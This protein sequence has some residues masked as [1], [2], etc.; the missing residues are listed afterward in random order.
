M[1]FA[2]KVFLV[3]SISSL[4][5]FAGMVNQRAKADSYGTQAKEES[6]K[7]YPIEAFFSTISFRGGFFS[8]DETK[9]LVSSD[10]TGIFNA[11]WIDI[12]TGKR[13][14]VTSSTAES[15]YASACF[16]ND[17]RI[18]YSSDKGGNRLFHLFVLQTDGKTVELTKGGASREEFYGWAQDGK[19]FFTVNTS[20]S[21]RCLDLCVRD[22]ETLKPKLVFENNG[23]Y[24][25]STI[26]PDGCWLALHK[27]KTT[28]DTDIYILDL[29]KGGEP[30]LI[31]AHEGEANFA[32][33]V[34]SRDSRYLYYTTDAGKDFACLKRCELET[35][36]HE[37]VFS[38]S[39]NV[40]FV[41][42]SPK[43]SYRVIGVE[44]DARVGI[45]VTKTA[46]GE[47]IDLPN[48]PTGHVE[49][50]TFSPSE[51]LM[52]ITLSND[53]LPN[54]I[55]LYNF[56]T[57]MLKQLTSALN[58]EIDPDDLVTSE[59]VR[60]KARDG[61]EIQGFLYKPKGAGASNKVP[62]LL[63]AHDGPVG[64]SRPIYSAEL[65]FLINHGY[66]IFAINQ[67][68]S[69]GYGRKFREADDRRWGREPLSDYLDAKSYLEKLDWVDPDRIGIMGLSIGGYFVLAGLTLHPDEFA[70][71]VDLFGICNMIRTLENLPR[72]L[73]AR[74]EAYYVE[75]GDPLLDDDELRRISPV[76]HAEKIKKPL[77]ILHGMNDPFVAKQD[78]DS[79]VAAIRARGGIVEYIVFEDVGFNFARAQ[80]RFK[81]YNAILAFLDKH[82]KG[83]D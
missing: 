19:S 8:H 53:L 21:P 83:A 58:P 7:Q 32:D 67:R 52:S 39:G 82:L 77:I 6:V 34:F 12:E 49:S 28:L 4:I 78:V 54:T 75:F 50:V 72:F 27:T 70:V 69:L 41:N 68:G 79:I 2:S 11:Y 55:F 15:V 62:A 81:A 20:R 23:D 73:A 33:S 17:D 48:L 45:E 22:I 71:G 5:L 35:G 10:E 56:G 47:V 16:P 18:I 74:R 44:K 66:A 25:V 46:T 42:F 13:T 38:T 57:G 9:L 61:L 60:F 26:S 36:T 51:E 76:F 3:L 59:A 29:K 65:Q 37:E 14:P 63:F 31:S 80:N 1:K 43:N 64:L 30:V 24:M 40:D